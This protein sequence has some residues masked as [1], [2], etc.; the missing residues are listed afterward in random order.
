[1]IGK[2]QPQYLIVANRRCKTHQRGS[3]LVYTGPRSNKPSGW[4]IMGRVL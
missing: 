2:S 3:R 4:T 1:M